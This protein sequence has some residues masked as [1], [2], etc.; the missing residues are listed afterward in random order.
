MASLQSEHAG[1]RTKPLFLSIQ[2]SAT[3]FAV[4]LVNAVG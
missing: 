3:E 2:H 1:F 4:P